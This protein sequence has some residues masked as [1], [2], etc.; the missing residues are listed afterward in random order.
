MRCRKDSCVNPRK[1]LNTLSGEELQD[2]IA[3]A[4]AL[5]QAHW[6]Y[7]DDHASRLDP[8]VPF[9]DFCEQIMEVSG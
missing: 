6:C 3:L 1:Y 9:T 2:T 8:S 5:Q 7:E 4:S